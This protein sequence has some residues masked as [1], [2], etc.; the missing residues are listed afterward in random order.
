M[1]RYLVKI[2]LLLLLGACSYYLTPHREQLTVKQDY[3]VSVHDLTD[4]DTLQDAYDNQISN[5][6]A[7]QTGR[8]VKILKDDKY[9]SNH[10]RFVVKLESGQNILIAHNID[11]A[12]KVEGFQTGAL[13][14]FKGEY[15]WNN[16]G[17]V[18]H[19]THHD[20]KGSHPNG[21]LFYNN[22]KYE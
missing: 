17:G 1:N 19:W 3:E 11:L 4:L 9:G 12:P 16:K 20:P 15:E 7:R 6:Q 21:W 22:R 8:I 18:I 2:V 10:Q 5:F 14:S 13:I